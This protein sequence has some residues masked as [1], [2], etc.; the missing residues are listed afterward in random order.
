VSTV[1][2]AADRLAAAGVPS[3][4][5]DA[6]ALAVHLLT[7][8]RHELPSD[9]LGSDYDALVER[10]AAREPLQY[11]VGTAAFR[12]L[13]VLVGPGVFVPRPETEVLVDWVISAVRT[14]DR[15]VVVDLCTGPGT[16][17]LAIAHEVPG[18]RVCAVDIDPVAIQWA[19]SNVE[20]TGLPVTLHEGDIADAFSELDGVVDAVVA[21][22]PYIPAVDADRLDPEVRDHEPARALFADDDGLAIVCTV[23]ATAQRLLRPGGVLAIE[24][25]EDQGEAVPGLVRAARFLD[26]TDHRDLAGRDRF[27]TARRA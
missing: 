5:H 10:R 22:P 24:H 14:V 21:N 8:P 16:I 18:A 23:I 7:T 13:D 17:A 20:H 1:R 11:I 26:V 15:P 27:T 6:E 9:D 4:R 25:G 12:R 19:R 3:P 2:A